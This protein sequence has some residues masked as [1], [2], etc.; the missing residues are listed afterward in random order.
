M[1]THLS[2]FA[3]APAGGTFVIFGLLLLLF[4]LLT[5]IHT[6]VIQC[7]WRLSQKLEQNLVSRDLF[8]LVTLLYHGH[9]LNATLRTSGKLWHPGHIGQ[10]NGTKANRLDAGLLSS[11]VRNGN[12]NHILITKVGLSFFYSWKIDK[13]RLVW[14]LRK[15]GHEHGGLRR[16]AARTHTEDGFVGGVTTWWLRWRRASSLGYRVNHSLVFNGH[17][18]NGNIMKVLK[19]T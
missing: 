1:S 18:L 14:W 6:I 15:V 7:G 10:A 2:V 4:G 16:T 13:A 17:F 8:F 5:R 19:L 9:G 11:T 3:G 12:R